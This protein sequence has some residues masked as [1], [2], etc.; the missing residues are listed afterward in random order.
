MRPLGAS[1]HGGRKLL[2]RIGG[3]GRPALDFQCLGTHPVHPLASDGTARPI[4]PQHWSRGRRRRG[5]GF[6][7]LRKRPIDRADP[8][9]APGATILTV[10]PEVTATAILHIGQIRDTHRASTLLAAF[11]HEERIAGWAKQRPIG[12]GKKG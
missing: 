6:L 8:S 10:R 2:R 9:G 5:W 3:R 4:A 11:S 12:L 1:P 7:P